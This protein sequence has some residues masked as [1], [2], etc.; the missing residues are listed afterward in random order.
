MKVLAIN[1][2][3][4]TLNFSFLSWSETTRALAGKY[5]WPAGSWRRSAPEEPWI[6]PPRTVHSHGRCLLSTLRVQL[7]DI[8]V[9]KGVQQVNSIESL[10]GGICDGKNFWETY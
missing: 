9:P 7:F 4:S 5:G 2:G 1:C 8:T 10:G 3:S 6:S